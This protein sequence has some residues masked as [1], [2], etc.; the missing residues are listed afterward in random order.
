MTS[1]HFF[2]VVSFL[3][4]SQLRGSKTPR[5]QNFIIIIII[6]LSFLKL[7]LIV[8]VLI[9]IYRIKHSIT[10]IFKDTHQIILA[11][12]LTQTHHNIYLQDFTSLIF[13]LFSERW[14]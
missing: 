6:I 11:I 3:A 10:D 8:I 2:V 4:P 1:R 9:D 13:L 12:L 5:R 14:S 7:N